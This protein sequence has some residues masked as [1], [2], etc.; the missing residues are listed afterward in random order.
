METKTCLE[1]VY[2]PIWNRDLS[3]VAQGYCRF[4]YD[5]ILLPSSITINVQTIKKDSPKTDCLVWEEKLLF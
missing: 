1:C 2:C 3:K 5:P 4:P